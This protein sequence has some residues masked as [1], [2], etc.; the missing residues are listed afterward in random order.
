MNALR[1]ARGKNTMLAIMENWM[2]DFIENIIEALKILHFPTQFSLRRL[3][4]SEAGM[5]F[6]F[7]EKSEEKKRASETRRDE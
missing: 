7:S 1:C 4:F 2:M 5:V 3:F 6:R